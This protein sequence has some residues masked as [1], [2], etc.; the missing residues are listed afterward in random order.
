MHIQQDRQSKLLAMVK[1]ITCTHTQI[2]S[3]YEKLKCMGL[4]LQ[5]L[6]ILLNTITESARE[7]GVSGA[8]VVNKF[9]DDVAK[10]IIS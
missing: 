10:I 4:G 1:Q 8:M 7:N 6:T 2:I 5:E 9:I 3:V